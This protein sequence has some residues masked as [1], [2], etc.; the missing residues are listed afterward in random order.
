MSVEIYMFHHITDNASRNAVYSLNVEIVHGQIV[1]K[2]FDQIIV[3]HRFIYGR[4]KQTRQNIQ[5]R[6]F[7]LNNLR[8]KHNIGVNNRCRCK[9]LT[10]WDSKCKPSA[11]EKQIAVERD[12]QDRSL[13]KRICYSLL[14]PKIAQYLQILATSKHYIAYLEDSNKSQRLCN[15]S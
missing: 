13:R 2:S 9:H 3:G 11:D 10:V 15:V 7:R 14:A 1:V 5:D 4:L 8:N 12:K 6:C